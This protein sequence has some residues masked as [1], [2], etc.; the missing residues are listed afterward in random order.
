M[1]A[2]RLRHL[3]ENFERLSLALKTP[4]PDPV[5]LFFGRGQ[6]YWHH[7][8]GGVTRCRQR[9]AARGRAIHRA[10]IVRIPATAA[11]A[12]NDLRF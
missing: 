2:P 9:A 11:L 12:I 6:P 7:E 5:A 1:A 8:I 4:S 10:I 3:S